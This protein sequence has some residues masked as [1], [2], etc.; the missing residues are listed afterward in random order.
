MVGGLM[1]LLSRIFIF[2]CCRKAVEHLGL[3]ISPHWHVH[4]SHN[5]WEN[6]APLIM[7][8]PRKTHGSCGLNVHHI[9]IN[10]TKLLAKSILH[11][12]TWLEQFKPCFA[13]LTP[14]AMIDHNFARTAS[15][16]CL[17]MSFY[18]WGDSFAILVYNQH[19]HKNKDNVLLLSLLNN[20]TL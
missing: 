6:V 18:P 20:N 8:T 19:S 11:I 4:I 12:R 17:I 3:L 7:E 13:V 10:R 14:N 2:F 5:E 15:K 16:N 1:E 9:R